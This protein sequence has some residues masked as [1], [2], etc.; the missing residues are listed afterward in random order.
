MA[1]SPSASDSFESRLREMAA[2]RLLET[3]QFAKSKEE[4]VECGSS[5]SL[6]L[7]MAHTMRACM[8]DWPS[9]EDNAEAGAERAEALTELK[10]SLKEARRLT[11]SSPLDS[12]V[13]VCSDALFLMAEQWPSAKGAAENVP[14]SFPQ[15]TKPEPSTSNLSMGNGVIAAKRPRFENGAK[16]ETPRKQFFPPYPENDDDEDQN[17]SGS[18]QPIDPL[19]FFNQNLSGLIK[20]EIDLTT[21]EKLE[22]TMGQGD[23]DIWSTQTPLATF[24]AVTSSTSHPSIER[25]SEAARIRSARFF[26]PECNLGCVAK[27]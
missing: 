2:D 14:L 9:M 26:C 8:R 5:T 23:H 12:L 6:L 4:T 19:M 10:K 11:R 7:S 24:A 27:S 13:F 15:K 18:S 21:N 25:D 16:T 22:T 17:A 1:S 20:E 3:V